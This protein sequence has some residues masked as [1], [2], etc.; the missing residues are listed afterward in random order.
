[1]PYS[2]YDC[3]YKGYFSML[4]HSIGFSSLRALTL[5]AKN[6]QASLIVFHSLFRIFVFDLNVA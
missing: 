2:N 1:M 6:I 4:Q 5:A 3:K